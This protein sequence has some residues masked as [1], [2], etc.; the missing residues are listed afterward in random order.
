MSIFKSKA[1]VIKAAEFKE[2]DKIIWLFTEKLGK[3]SVVAK[4]AKRS[5]SKFLSLT[6][7]FCFGNYVVFK[8]KSLYTLNEGEVVN[9][10]QFLLSNLESLTYASYL[11]ELIDIALV[12]EESNRELFKNFITVFYLMENNAVD[13]E[14]LLR[15]FE[16]KLI[17]SAGY[18]FN[19][20]NCSICGKKINTSNYISFEH[21]GGL[22]NDCRKIGGMSVSYSTYNTLKY[23]IK[24]PIENVYRLTL[25]KEN[26]YELYKL[27]SNII[28]DSFGKRPNSLETF[29]FIKGS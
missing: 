27:L 25:T 12:E 23:L 2:S 18:Y 21:L 5:K 22:C 14:L 7:P 10:F 1:M 13:Y 19:L 16:V 3:I 4:G 9:S 29:D 8:G 11:C 6:L 26:K 17:I 28:G 15:A 24:V 20:E